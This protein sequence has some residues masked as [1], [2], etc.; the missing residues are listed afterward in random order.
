MILLQERIDPPLF[1]VYVQGG[2]ASCLWLWIFIIV[3]VAAK[4]ATAN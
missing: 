2:Q 3:A 4:T 1:S